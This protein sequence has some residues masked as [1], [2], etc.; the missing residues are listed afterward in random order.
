MSSA[1][2]FSS[3]YLPGKLVTSVAQGLEV[4]FE[5]CKVEDKLLLRCGECG[6]DGFA[7]QTSGKLAGW[8]GMWMWML[9]EVVRDVR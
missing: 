4:E 7:L 5:L 6:C 2:R 9:G 3:A 1:P 8:M